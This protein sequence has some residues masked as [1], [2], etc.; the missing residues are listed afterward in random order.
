VLGEA[1]NSPVGFFSR[2]GFLTVAPYNSPL[3]YSVG[4]FLAVSLHCQTFGK[5]K[6]RN[7]RPEMSRSEQ[8]FPPPKPRL[9]REQRKSLELLASDPHGATGGQLVITHGF[10][11]KMPAALDYEGLAI[12]IVGKPAKA[13]GKAVEV[14]RITIREAG[15]RAIDG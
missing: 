7:D 11:T 14:V 13:G 9:T 1:S 12:A 6:P 8:T 2:P 5:V 4:A 15:M 10:E 3:W